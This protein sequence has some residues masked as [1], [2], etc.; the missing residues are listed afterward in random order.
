MEQRL[1]ADQLVTI[2]KVLGRKAV[3][4]THFV[5]LQKRC[6]L[7]REEDGVAQRFS[8]ITLLPERLF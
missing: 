8:Q 5:W 6:L 2:C 4:N 1:R 7:P 3:G